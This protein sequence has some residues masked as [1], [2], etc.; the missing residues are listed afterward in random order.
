[1]GKKEKKNLPV[2]SKQSPLVPVDV[3]QLGGNGDPCFGKGYDLSTKE[4]K[5]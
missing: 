3:T 4:C 1:M 5:L 2:L